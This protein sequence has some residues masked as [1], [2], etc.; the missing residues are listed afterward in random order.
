MEE[1]GGDEDEDMEEEAEE[2]Y[3]EVEDKD[4]LKA[5]VAFEKKK[6]EDNKR[7][8]VEDNKKIH[9]TTAFVK[10]LNKGGKHEKKAAEKKKAVEEVEVDSEM[11]KKKMDVDAG[12]VA[13]WPLTLRGHQ[14]HQGS[15]LTG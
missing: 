8:W 12:P 10:Q 11:T 2:E 4:E 6:A 7:K 5:W 9:E 13:P 14:C 15:P 3:V 1:E